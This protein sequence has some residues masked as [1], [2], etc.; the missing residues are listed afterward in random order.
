MKRTIE[1]YVNK[2]YSSLYALI[3]ISDV[4]IIGWLL[5]VTIICVRSARF[6]RLTHSRLGWGRIGDF[7]TTR[8]NTHINAAMAY[9]SHRIRPSAALSGGISFLDYA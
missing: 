7:A 8:T 6:T 4:C 1:R 5:R 2:K 3:N 9:D